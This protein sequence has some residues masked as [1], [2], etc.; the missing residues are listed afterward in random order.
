MKAKRKNR[1]V[2]C[3]DNLSWFFRV[4]FLKDVGEV[5]GQDFW[6]FIVVY[7]WYK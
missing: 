2:L 1:K 5:F 4:F 6:R 3:Y 7:F